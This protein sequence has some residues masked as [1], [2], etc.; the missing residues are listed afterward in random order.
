MLTE[1]FA[2]AIRQLRRVLP[3]LDPAS[4]SEPAPAGPQPPVQV[5]GCSVTGAKHEHNEDAWRAR[6]PTDETFAIAVADGLGSADHG[7][8]GASVAAE[9][10]VTELSTVLART[11]GEETLADV[12]TDERLQA[13]FT[14]ARDAVADR[15]R[16]LE[17]PIGSLG[18]TLIAVAGDRSGTAA[19]AVGDGGVVGDD[20]GTYFPVLDREAGEFANVTTPLTA[21][22]WTDAYR[23]AYTERADAVAAFTDGLG[24]FTWESAETASP[25]TAFFEQLF[26]PIH[27]A[28]RAADVEPALCAFL[29]AEHFTQ[30]SRDDKTLV[31]GVSR[32]RPTGEST[33]AESTTEREG[34][35][36]MSAPVEGEP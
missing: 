16:A 21:P 22:D 13:A 28:R 3:V 4:E 6:T 18:T 15:A 36:P 8:T 24:N 7:R 1:R 20:D 34:D 29:G 30:Y 32:P 33:T 9:A 5:V 25:E 2:A 17:V 26:P 19:A 11:D 27:A 14:A 23:F 31:V 35:R 12:A 10:A